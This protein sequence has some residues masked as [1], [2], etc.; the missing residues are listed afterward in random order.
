LI[1]LKIT[2]TIKKII[3]NETEKKNKMKKKQA[4]LKKKQ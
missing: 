2:W 4:E 1:G 3:K